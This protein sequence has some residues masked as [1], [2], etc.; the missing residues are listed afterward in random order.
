MYENLERIRPDLHSTTLQGGLIYGQHPLP[1]REPMTCVGT[2]KGEREKEG[3][4]GV[5]K[6]GGKKR[7]REPMTCTGT[8]K[9][10]SARARVRVH[11]RRRV[12]VRVRRRV[13]VRECTYCVS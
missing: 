1:T 11:V 3:G 6:E 10:T 9:G 4:G 8:N 13:R 2:D 7:G 5:G 12:R